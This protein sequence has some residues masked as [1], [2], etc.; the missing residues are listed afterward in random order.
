MK[1][2]PATLGL[3]LALAGTASAGGLAIGVPP[4]LPDGA[5]TCWMANMPSREVNP[6]VEVITRDGVVVR[7]SA[8]TVEGGG[9]RGFFATGMVGRCAFDVARAPACPTPGANGC[10]A[11]G[12]A[13]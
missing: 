2:T 11:T 8:F 6:T 12:A 1:R 4:G 9:V 3:L 7:S 5:V 13:R 10:P